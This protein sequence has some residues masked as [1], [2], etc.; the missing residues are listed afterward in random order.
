MIFAQIHSKRL[1]RS[2]IF[3]LFMNLQKKI[4]FSCE[5]E[6]LMLLNMTP[7]A[8]RS[9]RVIK[10]ELPFL[11]RFDVNRREDLYIS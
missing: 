11:R 4:F 6:Y 1:F 8:K 9:I 3:F 2:Y 5:N 10:H 7:R